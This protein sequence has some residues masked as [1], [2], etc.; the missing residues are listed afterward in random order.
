ME[1]ILHTK[2]ITG[3]RDFNVVIDAAS[4]RSQLEK[5][6]DVVRNGYYN[7]TMDFDALLTPSRLNPDHGV[8]SFTVRSFIGLLLASEQG[9]SIPGVKKERHHLSA[10]EQI[11]TYP[12][13]PLSQAIVLPQLDEVQ[14]FSKLLLEQQ[15]DGG[16]PTLLTPSQFLER[17][18]SSIDVTQKVLRERM[19][20]IKGRRIDKKYTEKLKYLEEHGYY[21]TTQEDITILG[22]LLK[23]LKSPELES[24]DEIIDQFI[25][26][27]L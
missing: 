10:D 3:T 25:E 24:D 22:D 16:N 5:D 15:K 19:K 17:L 1:D 18:K 2:C 11:I 27:R 7:R 12:M 9:L 26:N 23:L 14:S 8:E 4:L 13:P 21:A 6:V 20:Y